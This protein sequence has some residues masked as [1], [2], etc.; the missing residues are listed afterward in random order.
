M[1]RLLS[2]NRCIF[3]ASST[4]ELLVIQITDS[5]PAMSKFVGYNVIM[6]H[7]NVDYITWL[8]GKV[9]GWGHEGITSMRLFL[10]MDT[11]YHQLMMEMH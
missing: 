8:S 4:N 6:V 11:V 5:L 7:I 10:L 1:V 3:N 2:L 9:G